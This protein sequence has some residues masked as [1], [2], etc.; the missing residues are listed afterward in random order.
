MKNIVTIGGGTGSFTVLSGLKQYTHHISAIMPVTDEGGSTGVL[1]DQFGILPP[2]DI[3]QALLALSESGISADVLRKLFGH[4]FPSG[5]L[6]GHNFG[7]LFLT[8]L[9]QVS[10]SFQEAIDMSGRLLRCRGEVIPSTL[11][12]PRLI[13]MLPNGQNII[14]EEAFDQNNLSGLIQK[15]DFDSPVTGN[16]RAIEAIHNADLII[17][18][19]GSLYTSLITNLLPQGIKE[20]IIQSPAKKALVANLMTKQ[21][22]SENYLVRDM[23]TRIEDYLV[24]DIFDF[25][26]VSDKSPSQELIDNYAKEG[27]KFMTWKRD[28]F[29]DKSL[30]LIPADI[31]AKK[32]ATDTPHDM[33]ADRNLIRYD[34]GKL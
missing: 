28:D 8:A 25:L 21:C 31:I 10:G 22:D 30:T 5:D 13:A 34:P 20:A 24:P 23:L 12:T 3:R 9:E 26:V 4:R 29:E 2:G 17:I 7:N 19:P 27:Q 15:I 11:E 16:Q 33:V 18:G 1:R 32:A 6:Q 14:G